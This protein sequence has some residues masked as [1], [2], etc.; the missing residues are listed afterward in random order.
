MTAELFRASLTTALS[1]ALSSL[2]PA[3]LVQRA[4]GPWPGGRV[5]VISAG[6]AALRMM[7][8]VD[9]AYAG[10]SY[11]ALSVAPSYERSRAPPPSAAQGASRSIYF[12]AHPTPDEQSLAAGADALKRAEALGGGD[13]LIALV[14]GGASSL[15]ATLP[16]GLTLARKQMA[17]RALL[18]RGAPIAD[19]NT[20]RRHLSPI[21][22]GG[23]A[24]AAAPA[25]VTCLLLSDV[26][27]G[28]LCDVASGPAVADPT[29][30]DDARACIARWIPEQRSWLE[31]HLRETLAMGEQPNLEA[32]VLADPATL[33]RAMASAL[34]E[35]MSLSVTVLPPES[36]DLDAVVRRRLELARQ[37]EPG[38]AVVVPCEPT[39]TLP[40]IRGSGGRAG[41]TALEALPDLPSSV[42]LLCAAS[43]GVDG[44]S[45]A[46]GAVVCG[47][48]ALRLDS[49]ELNRARIE[50][51]DAVVHRALGT[52]IVL[53]PTGTNL[54]DV[55]VVAR[56]AG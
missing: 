29:T 46:A 8:G 56:P 30:L 13:Q 41:R 17:V 23:L 47:A 9:L 16:P 32:L 21:K 2:D 43:D 34:T 42:F 40:S 18:E 6:K 4:L 7:H 39:V 51:D 48:D 36:L 22:G 38:Q 27:S 25:R 12:A 37:L 15:L 44:T 20:V 28:R 35:R 10:H 1:L 24:Q 53:G 19:V 11:D 14:S 55:H 54:T 45:S 5:S 49:E 52:S 33:G 3:E 26:V 50:F 31:P